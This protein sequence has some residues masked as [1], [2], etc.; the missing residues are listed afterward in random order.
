AH[1]TATPGG[2]YLGGQ[3][4]Y[5]ALNAA[6]SGGRGTGGGT[7]VGDM[8]SH[9]PDAG[10]FAGYGRLFK[11]WYLGLEVEGDRSRADFYH[12]NDKADSRTFSLERNNSYGLSA[13]LGYALANGALLYGRLGAARTQFRTPYLENN[14]PADASD[15]TDTER[16]IRYGVGMDIPTDSPLFVRL[17]YAYTRY[18]SYPV[19]YGGAEPEVFTPS[20]GQFRLGAG[21]RFGA[22]PTPAVTIPAA[23][24]SGLY[25]GAAVGQGSVATTATGLL[26]TQ[27]TGPDNFNADFGNDGVS[28]TAF[29]GYGLTFHRVYAGLELAGEGSRTTWTHIRDTSG[30][31]G[32]TFSVEKQ[33]G[34]GAALRLGY[35]LHNGTL[36]YGR[37]GRIHTK[38]STRYDKG[39]NANAYIYQD[40]HETGTR[41]GVGADV[42]VGQRL[43]VR[44]DYSYTRYPS[45]GFVTTQGGGT[46]ADQLSYKNAESLFRVG[47]GLRF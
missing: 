7:D 23:K 5:G 45:Y 8:G 38:F 27:G 32:R 42:P 41:L 28:S 11:R 33:G 13:R 24:V 16:G 21:W 6:T 44:A 1:P 12:I 35:L 34:Y 9:G 40:D 39:A 46:N 30:S 47:L 19:Y 10:L 17:D 36:L 15:Q 37:I 2:F 4:G 25:V 31:G 29:V 26:R 20:E 43:F 22:Q 14:L 18:N 3:V